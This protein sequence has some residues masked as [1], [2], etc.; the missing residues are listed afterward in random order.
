MDEAILSHP[1]YFLCFFLFDRSSP[2][3]D[4][5]VCAPFF[6]IDKTYVAISKAIFIS[7]QLIL[8]WKNL[9]AVSLVFGVL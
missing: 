1:F 2:A 3:L 5:A 8:K 6:T 9:A 7:H 4:N